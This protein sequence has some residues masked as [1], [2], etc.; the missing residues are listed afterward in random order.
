VRAEKERDEAR[1]KLKALETEGDPFKRAMV[2]WKEGKRAQAVKTGFGVKAFDDDFLVQV[3]GAEEDPEPLTEEQLTER[4]RKQLEADR[5]THATAQAEQLQQLRA[6]A[7]QEVGAVL[8]AA[9]EKWPTVWALGI[10][11]EQLAA[12]LDAS[13]D[14]KTGRTAEPDKLFDDLEA[15]ARAKIQGLPWLP[16]AAEPTPAP[17]SFGQESRRGPVDQPDPAKALTFQERQKLREQREQEWRVQRF[18][19]QS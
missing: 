12:A 14:P 13:F 4:I 17:R 1:G 18:R 19:T 5:Q 9:P 16:K 3:A 7:V 10:T 15:E 6:G 2:L 8:V 11:G